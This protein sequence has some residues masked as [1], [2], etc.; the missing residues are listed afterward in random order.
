MSALC[1]DSE[2][3]LEVAS[4]LALS[5]FMIQR[6]THTQKKIPNIDSCGEHRPARFPLAGNALSP[7]LTWLLLG[8]RRA[9]DTAHVHSLSINVQQGYG[10]K[11]LT[12]SI[13][14]N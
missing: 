14:K 3:N 7:S 10:H 11:K 8:L 13:D 12:L 9:G 6:I 2:P 1:L 5:L 4:Q